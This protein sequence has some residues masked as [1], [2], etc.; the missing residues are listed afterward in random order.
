MTRRQ[1]PWSGN[2]DHDFHSAHPTRLQE[3]RE[4]TNNQIPFNWATR[5][6]AHCKRSRS[7]TQYKGD[8]TTCKRCPPQEK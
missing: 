8:S 1:D 6:C 3:L 7:L 5:K 2:H 4:R